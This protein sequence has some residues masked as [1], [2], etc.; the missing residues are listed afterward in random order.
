MDAAALRSWWHP[1]FIGSIP[2]EGDDVMCPYVACYRFVGFLSAGPISKD[3]S[4][5]EKVGSYGLL[6]LGN[7]CWTTTR[8]DVLKP[9]GQVHRRLFARLTPS[10]WRLSVG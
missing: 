7:G 5:M 6:V 8:S 3:V 10:V 9:I 4:T 1:E 2:E